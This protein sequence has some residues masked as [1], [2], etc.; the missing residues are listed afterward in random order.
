[1]PACC[2]HQFSDDGFSVHDG[3]ASLIACAGHA[4][5]DG[6]ACCRGCCGVGDDGEV[7]P[8]VFEQ[9][10]HVAGTSTLRQDGQSDSQATPD[11]SDATPTP[12]EAA[13]ISHVLP[14]RC[15]SSEVRP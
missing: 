13:R 2:G 1:V 4:S 6:T 5:T 14:R 11:P 10:K 9:A 3:P 8:P 7:W 12:R 15:S